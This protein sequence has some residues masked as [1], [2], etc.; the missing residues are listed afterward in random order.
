MPSKIRVTLGVCVL[1]LVL[2]PASLGGKPS[3]G[4]LGGSTSGCSISPTQVVLDQVWTVAAAGLSAS[5]VN[6]IITFPD[7]GKSY[8]PITVASGGTFTTTGNSNMSA[9]W[10]VI[11]AEQTGTYTYQFVNNIKWSTGAF[12]KLYASCSVVVS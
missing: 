7:G 4:T 9:A 3:G 6:M 10:G 11:P 2:V 1:A 8:G 5:N 12:T